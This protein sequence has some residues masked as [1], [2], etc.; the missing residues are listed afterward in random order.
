MSNSNSV[1]TLRRFVIGTGLCLCLSACGI[2]DL[3]EVI[4]PPPPP[5]I[6]VLQPALQSSAQGPSLP[7]Q[8]TVAVPDAPASIDTI[9]IALN[10]TASTLDY[11][12][13]AAWAD[14]AP[15][16][17]QSLLIQAF[18]EA[19]R[20]AVARDTDGLLAD[21][22]L[23]TEMREFQAHYTGGIAP[24]PD[25]PASPP[26]ISVRIDARLVSV[27]ERRVVENISVSHSAQARSNEMNGIVAA[28]N[29]ALGAAL[30]EIVNWTLTQATEE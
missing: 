5:Q 1:A 15:V 13:D 27:S 29:E 19:N 11:F 10:P 25:Q 22:L 7:L 28:F 18:E 23:R 20:V 8:L 4:S 16:L 17:V 6:Y 24:S 3:G 12:A 14:R 30:A 21:Y 9:R 26:E 2:A